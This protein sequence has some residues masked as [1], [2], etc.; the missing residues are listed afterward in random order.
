[1]VNQ[2]APKETLALNAGS[3]PGTVSIVPEETSCRLLAV[4]REDGKL[5]GETTVAISAYKVD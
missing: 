2:S 5:G 3:N 1:M 4:S